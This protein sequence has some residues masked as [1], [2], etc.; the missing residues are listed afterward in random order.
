MSFKS[1]LVATI[2]VSHLGVVQMSWGAQLQRSAAPKDSQAGTAQNTAVTPAM[3][4]GSFATVAIATKFME[5][6]PKGNYVVN[7]VSGLGVM[8]KVGIRI[9][10]LV[11]KGITAVAIIG[12]SLVLFACGS[13]GGGDMTPPAPGGGGGTTGTVTGTLTWSPNTEADLASY[14]V[15]HGESHLIYGQ[16]I[17]IYSGPN[18]ASKTNITIT[19]LKTKPVVNYF[20]V[21]ACDTLGNCSPHGSNE[22][23]AMLPITP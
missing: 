7:I 14:K 10:G 20:A 5:A 23:N 2:I 6:L 11:G 1:I 4:L 13:G 12:T 9:P 3:W 19:D 8:E 22:I 16:P 17:T 18:D 15:Y 21:D